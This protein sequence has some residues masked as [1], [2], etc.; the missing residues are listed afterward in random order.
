M[1]NVISRRLL[2][3]SAAASAALPFL[4]SRVNAAD[5]TVIDIMSDG[6][7]NI[8]DWWTNTLAPMFEKN[9]LVFAT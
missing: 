5:P 1:T 4:V 2:L 8:T 3:Q 9:W 7:T 6:D